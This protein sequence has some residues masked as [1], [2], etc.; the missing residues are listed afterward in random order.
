MTQLPFGYCTNVHA[1]TTLSQAKT[2]LLEYASVVRQKTV[3]DGVLPLGLWL[4]E[5]AAT[6]LSETQQS[7][8]FSN[9]LAEHHFL[10]YTLNGFPQHD[11]HQPV[12]KHEVYAPDW[13]QP[14]RR[15]YTESLGRSLAALLPAGQCG[16]IS[17]LP[18]G[19]PHQP[20]ESTDFQ[21]A[22]RQLL[23]VA[24]EFA[25]IADETQKHIVLA[26]EPEPG[27][28]LDTADDML[29]FFQEFL[30][31]S[32]ASDWARRHLT[33]CHDMCHSAVMFES[34]C[35]ALQKYLEAGIRVGK[36]QVSSAVHV[37]W[38]RYQQNPKGAGELRE[39]LAAFSEPKFLH[40]TTRSGSDGQL[41]AFADDLTAALADW[42]PDS[43]TTQDP[44]RV[45]FHVP[46]FVEAIGDL[47]TT[48]ADIQ[49]ATAFLEKNASI[50]LD[51]FPWFTGHYEVETYAW[52]VLPPALAVSDLATG[53]SQE[54]LYFNEVLGKIRR[55]N[56]R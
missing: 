26:L 39:Q 23:L 19:W 10:P 51:G 4:P 27:C 36:A 38:D 48:R 18:L 34:Q 37:P 43:S 33:I 41:L 25:R 8:E 30:F 40:Q 2:N 14:S 12:V 7:D 49:T 53:I 56:S 3:V 13:R 24:E 44:W 54:L 20:W 1:G 35:E 32:P 47:L 11:F 9:W 55:D 50:S 46:I 15:H 21:A 6:H 31:T 45:H 16:S 42:G 22:A 17:T 52:T 28:V 5:R 29:R